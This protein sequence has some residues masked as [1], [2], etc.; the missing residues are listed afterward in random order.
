MIMMI[1]VIITITIITIKIITITTI[2]TMI[3]IMIVM[4]ITRSILYNSFP[5]IQTNINGIRKYVILSAS[6][7]IYANAKVENIAC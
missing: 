4:I 2:T 5:H 1:L 6:N 3:I 7:L